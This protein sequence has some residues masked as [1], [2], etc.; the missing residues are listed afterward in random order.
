M[1]QLLNIRKESNSTRV[2]GRMGL[3]ASDEENALVNSLHSEEWPM[4]VPLTK[5]GAGYQDTRVTTFKVSIIY[6]F[7][8]L[9]N[10]NILY[11]VT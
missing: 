2:D 9:L 6:I 5:L 1:E 10:H 4:L 11:L 3:C 7:C 8:C